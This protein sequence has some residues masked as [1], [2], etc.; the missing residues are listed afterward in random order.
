MLTLIP[1]LMKIATI[2]VQEY[3]NFNKLTS[4]VMLRAV[5]RPVFSVEDS[6]HYFKANV[7]LKTGHSKLYIS[8]CLFDYYRKLRKLDNPL[9]VSLVDKQK[10]NY[11]LLY[12]SNKY[13]KILY[14]YRHQ[15]TPPRYISAKYYHG[16]VTQFH[17]YHLHIVCYCKHLNLLHFLQNY[18]TNIISFT[19]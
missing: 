11:S 9:H 18:Q 5:S 12:H 3:I 15:Q 17:V 6:L 1:G 2:R 13:V 16:L 10:I 14:Y 8:I 19:A 4:V 7:A